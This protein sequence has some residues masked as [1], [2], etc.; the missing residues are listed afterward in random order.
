MTIK[1]IIVC[2]GF[3][4]F[5]YNMCIYIYIY[6]YFF[7]SPVLCLVLMTLDQKHLTSHDFG[8]VTRPWWSQWQKNP[9][10]TPHSWKHGWHPKTPLQI[11]PHFHK[12]LEQGMSIQQTLPSCAQS[13]QPVPRREIL[14]GLTALQKKL[15]K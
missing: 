6:I 11:S 12:R 10:N 1:A 15:G 14:P 4:R 13:S 2:V 8:H 5:H 7:F 9:Q 3:D